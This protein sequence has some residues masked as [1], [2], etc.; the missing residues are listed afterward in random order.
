PARPNGVDFTK[1]ELLEISC[2]PLP[3]DAAALVTQ[4]STSAAKGIIQRSFRMKNRY[5]VP[6]SSIDRQFG[7]QLRDIAEFEHYGKVSTTLVRTPSG[8]NE[9]DPASGGFPLQE[10]ITEELLGSVEQTAVLLPLC[11]RRQITSNRLKIPAIDETSR[12]DG[13]RYGGILS[14][15]M[16]EGDQLTDAE[17]NK[18]FKGR[19]NS[20]DTN[21]LEIFAVAGEELVDDVPAFGAHIRT[22]VVNEMGFRQDQAIF[23]GGGA[24]QR[25]GILNAPAT[26]E[27]A[28]EAAQVAGTVLR[29]N[30]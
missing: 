19:Q 20:F 22:V 14:K 23:A 8:L 13:L 7:E 17:L 10:Q 25:L 26:I 24:G 12:A 2:V 1:V 6:R 11:D 4:R 16:A 28:K 15:W 5:N 21:K 3:S 9:G 27:I 30:I 29:E 18:F